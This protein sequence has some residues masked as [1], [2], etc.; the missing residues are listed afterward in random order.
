[1]SLKQRRKKKAKKM[2]KAK[3]NYLTHLMAAILTSTTG[4]K[5]LMKSL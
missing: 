1:L 2:V 4:A 3:G 5:L